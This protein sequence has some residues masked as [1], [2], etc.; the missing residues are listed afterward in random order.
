M[1]FYQ[2]YFINDMKLLTNIVT[3]T[4][5]AKCYRFPYLSIREKINVLKLV[6]H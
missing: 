2:V 3:S 5:K 4:Y 1:Y 6:Q